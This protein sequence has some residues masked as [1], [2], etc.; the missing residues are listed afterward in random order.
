MKKLL[1]LL[2]LPLTIFCQNTIGL[3]SVI[4]YPKQVYSAGLQ[5]WDITQDKNGIIYI[6]NNEGLLSFD[7]KN[8]SLFPLPNK[9][10]VRSVAICNDNKIY[11]GGQDEIGYF[12]PAKNGLLQ[13]HSLTE[14]IP[15]KDRAFGDVWDIVPYKNSIFFRSINK[16]FK[17]SNQSFA[18]Y[19][20]QTEWAYLSICND[21]LYAQDSKFGIMN[22]SNNIWQPLFEKN[23]L[24]A[25]DP[26]TAILPL[27]NDSAIITTLKNGLLL[28]SKKGIS[29]FPSA[30]NQLFKNDRIYAATKINANTIALATNNNGIYIIDKKGNLIQ[31]FS[32]TEGLQNNNVL[33]IFLDN[34]ANLWLGL[35]NGIDFIAYN[36]AIKSITPALQN[37]SSYA[38]IIQGN[39]LFIG[40]SNGLFSVLLEPEKKDLSFSKGNFSIVKNTF[41]QVWSLNSINNQL[42]LGH[43]EGA[44]LVKNN[45]VQPFSPNNGFWNFTPTSTTFPTPQIIAGSYRGISFFNYKNGLFTEEQEVPNFHESS[46][47]FAVDKD[48]N[49]WVSH[50]Y[51]GIYKIVKNTTGL[52]KTYS[53]SNK[54]GLPSLLNNHVFKIK[55]DVVFATEKGIYTYDVLK[56][57]F[58]PSVFY[59]KILGNQSLRYLKEDASGNIWFIHEKTLG[60]IDFSGKEPRIIYLPELTNKMLSGFEFIYPVNDNNIFVGGEKGFF[61]INYEKYK[62]TI[63]NL[64]IQIRGVRIIDK[65]D[66]LLFGGYFKDVNE[67]QLQNETDNVPKIKSHWK[68]LHLEFSSTLFGYQSNLTYSYRLKGFDDNWSVWGNRTEKEYTNLPAANYVF[69]VKVRS[70]L[71]NESAPA[72]F[73]FKILPPWYQ[74]IWAKIFYILLFCSF[75]YALNKWQH[76][77]FEK[78]QAKIKEEQTRL[79]YIHELEINKTES[80]L[81]TLRNE[82]LEADINFKNSELASSAM[83]LVKKGELLNKIKSELTHI[84]KGLDNPQAIAE[85]K[86]LIKS[87]GEDDNIDLEWAHFTKHFDKVHSGFL[88]ELKEIHPNITSNELKLSAYLRMNLSTKEIA[89]LMNISVRG[90][91][92]S[93][94]RLRKKLSIDTETNLFD[95]LIKIQGKG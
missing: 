66:S 74:T 33:S 13:Y 31:S 69:E 79:V 19:Y 22:F 38:A 32:K 59:N 37:G 78:K 29:T 93:R 1:L 62:Q 51:H 26:V 56:D 21:H 57:I 77:K 20:S 68:T 24:P 15:K 25:N 71:G 27:T 52:F 44:F 55:N 70:N 11:V 3:P 30:N 86:K 16:I 89:Q 85:L 9:T 8:W 63:P 35:D 92:I 88:A 42:L 36:S 75:V 6:A 94:Y 84:M 43:H 7:G 65:T 23:E 53:Y 90:I 61:N 17:L 2:C 81:V 91:E 4:N 39:Q 83:H 47:F 95:Y 48:D 10:N 49:I 46:R 67:P 41:G 80:E 12:E 40:T 28:L 82:K 45:T 5:N 14:L 64:H 50:P 34:Q 60:V 18:T 72:T 54:N 58:E 76:K 73:A 87:L